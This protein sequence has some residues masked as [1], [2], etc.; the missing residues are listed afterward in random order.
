MSI[1]A[2]AIVLNHSRARGAAKLVL[3]GIA[4]H[5]NPDNDGAWPSQAKLA[6]YANVSD[7]AVR[8][9]IDNLVSLG[10]LRYE[11]A[12]G[13]SAN[14]Y[15]PNR[16]WLTL[17]CPPECDGTASHRHRV[18]VSDRQGGSFKQSGWKQAS[19]KPLREPEEEP[20]LPQNKFEE[21]FNEFW[22]LYPRKVEKI[23]ARKAF[24]KAV[25]CH[26]LQAVMEGVQA[27]ATDPNLPAKQ[28]IP[29]P[30]SWLRAGGWTNEPYPEREQTPEEKLAL[31]QAEIA[32]RREKDLEASRRLR[33][34][35]AEA[36]RRYEANPP[37][38]CEHGRIKVICPKCPTPHIN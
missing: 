6:Q 36:Q 16:Y 7:R 5:L 3:I 8:D 21:A 33:E 27:L 2:M 34:E 13:Q 17:T 1:E 38:Y 25:T 22:K 19:D 23:D 15:K 30:A 11:V 4:N 37:A 26:G 20:I 10:E 24:D 29:Y 9:A 28:F 35:M 32:R 12:Q 18:E 31:Q 14:Q